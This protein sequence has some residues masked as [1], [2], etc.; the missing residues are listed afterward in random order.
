MASR[1]RLAALVAALVA[2]VVLFLA[3]G[4]PAALVAAL[5]LAAGTGAALRSTTRKD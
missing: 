5:A 2:A 3:S 1:Y 4:E